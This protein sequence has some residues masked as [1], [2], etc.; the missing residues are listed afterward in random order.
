MRASLRVD[1]FGE[2]KTFT[3]QLRETNDLFGCMPASHRRLTKGLRF[4][5][6][7]YRYEPADRLDRVRL[8]LRKWLTLERIVQSLMP[9]GCVY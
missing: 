7:S 5:T 4:G 9:L 2:R 8:I 3:A 1:L 6:H